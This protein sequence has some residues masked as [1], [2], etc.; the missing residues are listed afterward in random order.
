MIADKELGEVMIVV[1]HG[2]LCVRV[3]KGWP[4]PE[5]YLLWSRIIKE[6][7]PTGFSMRGMASEIEAGIETMK[8]ELAASR[9]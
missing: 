5:Q 9:E 3:P 4:Y 1:E 6:L 2:F 7:P 8:K